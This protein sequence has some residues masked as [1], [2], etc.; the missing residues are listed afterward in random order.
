M[1]LLK[2]RQAVDQVDARIVQLICEGAVF[3]RV[4]GFN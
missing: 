1:Q 3:D 2:H 4:N